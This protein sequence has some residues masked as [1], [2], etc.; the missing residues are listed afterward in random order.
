MHD[1]M[2]DM[3][4]RTIVGI[5]HSEKFFGVD[6]LRGS[7]LTPL[8]VNVRV[9]NHGIQNRLSIVAIIQR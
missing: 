9:S 5:C 3:K 1:M 8:F 7:V 6:V 2:K 4:R